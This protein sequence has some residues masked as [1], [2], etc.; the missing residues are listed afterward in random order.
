[1][2]V[3]FI[4]LNFSLQNGAETAAAAAAAEVEAQTTADVGEVAAGRGEAGAAGVQEA[5]VA[6]GVAAA[7]SVNKRATPGTAAL[8]TTRNKNTFDRTAISAIREI[9]LSTE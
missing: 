2:E 6:Q 1:M 8:I 9:I 4:Y 3:G 5:K 7:A